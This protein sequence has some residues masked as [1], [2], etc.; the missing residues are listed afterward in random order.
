MGVHLDGEAWCGH[1]I[2]IGTGEAYPHKLQ[3][4]GAMSPQPEPSSICCTRPGNDS[5]LEIH[6]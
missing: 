6:E 1:S 3:V 4:V 2:D 5:S